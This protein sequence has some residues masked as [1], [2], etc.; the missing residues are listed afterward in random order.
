MFDFESSFHIK[1]DGL[2][3]THI[4]TAPDVR[5]RLLNDLELASAAL[6]EGMEAVVIKSHVESTAG[7]ARLASEATGMRVLGGVTLN[8]SVGGLNPDAVRAAARMG[9]R[10][11]WLPTV[12][13]GNVTGDLHEIMGIIGEHDMVLGTGHLKPDEIFHVLDIAAEYRIRKVIVNHPLTGVVGA[14]LEEQKEM[15][16]RAYL[17]H[18]LVAC[19]PRHDGLDFRRI[20]EAV[21]YVGPER[22]ILATDFGQRHNPSPMD[23]LKQFIHLMRM[24]GFRDED[25]IRMCRD[26]PLELIS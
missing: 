20:T 19:M 2:V 13:A 17:E 11:V 15:S 9:G 18:C 25:I 21:R 10:F 5:E 22:C 4:H 1:L 7:R 24:E 12:S 16:G 26:N 8:D 23:G 14:S 3:D 6:R